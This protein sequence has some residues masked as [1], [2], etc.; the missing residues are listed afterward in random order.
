[1]FKFDVFF[2]QLASGIYNFACSLWNHHTDTFLQQISSGSESAVLSSLERTLL[3]LKGTVKRDVLQHSCQVVAWDRCLSPLSLGK[4]GWF[5]CKIRTK[6][7]FFFSKKLIK[8]P[9]HFKCMNCM[10]LWPQSSECVFFMC[11]YFPLHFSV[12]ALLLTLSLWF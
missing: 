6:E 4:M 5:L 2:L 12:W 3:S 1:M 11:F 10:L 7:L 8:I 9:S